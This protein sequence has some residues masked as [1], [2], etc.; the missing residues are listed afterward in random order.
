M[1]KRRMFLAS[2]AAALAMPA[3]ARAESESV[4]RFIPQADLSVL[5][6]VWTTTYQTRDHGFLVFDTLFG[7]DD[8]LQ[9][10]AADG[11]GREHR[12]RRQALDASRCARADVPRQHA[13]AGAG[14]RGQRAALGSAR[15][16]R[17]GA[18][19]GD[20]RDHR[21]RRQ[22]ASCSG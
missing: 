6:P 21:A 9:P 8:Q 1:I 10:A 11:R 13:G 7:L 20:R 22:D 14:L 17:P 16:V 18:D 2:G 19:G 5:D 12:G 3:L 15:R 4:L